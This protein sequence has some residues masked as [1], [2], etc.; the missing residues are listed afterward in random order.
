VVAIKRGEIYFVDLNPVK[1]KETGGTNPLRYWFCLLTPSITCQ[2]F[3]E[4]K[5]YHLIIFFRIHSFYIIFFRENTCIK[6]IR[7][8]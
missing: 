8:P 1:G 3:V 5:E 4:M 7:F 2:F 6:I